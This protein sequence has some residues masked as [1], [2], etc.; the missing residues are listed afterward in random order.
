M[1]LPFSCYAESATITKQEIIGEWVTHHGYSSPV[2]TKATVNSLVITP[3]YNVIF[4][5]NF[6]SGK[7]Q[8]YRATLNDIKFNE[9]IFIIPLLKDNKINYKLVLSGWRNGKRKL[10]FGTLFLYGEGELFNG[11][12]VS[13]KPKTNK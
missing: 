3:E 2:Q 7:V 12:P 9:E 10:V 4:K 8:T 11:I 1:F 13:F 6:P 5:R